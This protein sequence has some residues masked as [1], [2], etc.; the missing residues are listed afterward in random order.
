MIQIVTNTWTVFVSLPPPSPLPP[1]ILLL[2]LPISDI[3]SVSS[4]LSNFVCHSSIP[5]LSLCSPLSSLFHFIPSVHRWSTCRHS[6]DL[7]FN[8]GR[9]MTVGTTLIVLKSFIWDRRTSFLIFLPNFN[10]IVIVVISNSSVDTSHLYKCLPMSVWSR[11]IS[12]Y[13]WHIAEIYPSVPGLFQM[14]I[15][16]NPLHLCWIF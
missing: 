15:F 2:S 1:P 7:F 12:N 5:T 10:L 14:R 11:P 16:A 4:G 9:E 3:M 13:N 8:N 6:F